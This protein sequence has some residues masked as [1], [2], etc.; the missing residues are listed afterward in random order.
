L[1]RGAL[2]L[3][4]SVGLVLA[5]C[6][7]RAG[8]AAEL[9][10][11]VVTAQKR[12]EDIQSV[13]IAI[14]AFS[15]SDLRELG[16]NSLRDLPQFTPNVA[17]FD[18]YGTG[19]PTWVIRGVGLT[20]F[21]ANNTPTAA[22]Y[23]DD[24]YMTSNVMGGVGL[25]D[26]QQVEVLKGPQGALYGR[27]TSGGAIRV[28]SNKPNTDAVGG[29]A[30]LSY[31]D[32]DQTIAEGALN[33]PVG[34]SAAFRVAGQFGQGGHGW[35]TSLVDGEKHGKMDKWA[36]RAQ[37]LANLTDSTELLLNVH[38]AADSSET[39]LGRG[40][41]LYSTDAEAPGFCSAILSGHLDDKNC[42]MEATF[43]DPEQRM[44]SVQ[45]NDGRK[46]LS[47]PINQFDNS[48]QGASAR[49]TVKF[50]NATLTSVTA[51]EG[52]DYGLTFDYDGS[53]GEF[54]HQHAKSTIDAWSQSLWLAS[55][56][57]GPVSWLVGAEYATDDL[58]EN[59]YFGIKSDLGLV[60]LVGFDSAN[61]RYDQTT[62]SAAAFG[63][64][65]WKFADTLS[66]NLGVRYTD[67]S[68]NYRHGG[69]VTF[70]DGV[71]TPYVE[72]LHDE[73]NLKVWSW[74]TGLDWTP[75][76]DVLFYGSISKGFK[77]GGFF[78]GFPAEGQDSISPYDP[79]TVLAYEV[80]VKSEWF[81]H[82]LRLNGALFYYDYRDVQ[83]YFT[84]LNIINTPSTRLGNLGDA[85]HKGAELDL[86]WQ[87]TDHL[88]LQAN[89]GWLDA[90]I[91]DSDA[92]TTSWLGTEVPLEGTQRFNAPDFSYFLRGEYDI[93][94]GRF[95]L[96]TSLDYS[97][98]DSLRGFGASVIEDTLFDQL[99]AYGLLGARISL[100]DSDAHWN[101]ALWGKNLADEKYFVNIATD[102]V[103]S[104]MEIP[105]APRSYGIELRYDWK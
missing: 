34:E 75:T 36:A 98:R 9:E 12:V 105:G 74:K 8:A 42:A 77:S 69:F 100:S 85:E 33:V 28:I 93:P 20:D 89:A 68:K 80:G 31:N 16:A 2:T 73:T 53:D 79:E 59:R 50:D 44:P 61:L 30:S 60:P 99:K 64:V 15:A 14:S 54:G 38:G 76:D 82:T 83:G 86:T 48:S 63:Q 27:N 97:W 71:E 88:T 70:L 26:L 39:P 41:G 43:Y 58:S 94:V 56:N 57:D 19:Q 95:N 102:D 32:W 13:G 4:V 67:E 47:D 29:Y 91:A 84:I 49:I 17:L 65:N 37:F 52:F 3:R 11:I 92:T 96:S 40:I 35:Q 87:A 45:S 46:T 104:W 6:G 81:D 24:V 51:Y 66:F 90:K 5:A 7:A 10:E 55:T 78:G 1:T 72:G 62:E 101:V 23:V 103:A 25:F 21:N 22:I 18:E